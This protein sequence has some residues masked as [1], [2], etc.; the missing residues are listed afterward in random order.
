MMG[1]GEWDRRG[2]ADGEAEPHVVEPS[3]EHGFYDLLLSLIKIT[4][5]CKRTLS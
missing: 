4:H 2:E 1:S 5:G 3:A